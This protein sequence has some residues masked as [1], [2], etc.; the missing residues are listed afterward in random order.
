[1]YVYSTWMPFLDG[2]ILWSYM[3]AAPH[4][5]PETLRMSDANQST[6]SMMGSTRDADAEGSADGAVY[7]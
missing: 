1:M 3:H 4:V 2:Y 6:A 7:M 5:V